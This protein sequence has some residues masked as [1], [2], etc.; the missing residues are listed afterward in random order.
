M[1]KGAA[2]QLARVAAP[3]IIRLRAGSGLSALT[4]YC[5]LLAGQ[6]AGSGWDESEFDVAAQLVN[7]PDATVLDVGAN[8]GSWSLELFRRLKGQPHFHMFECAPICLPEAEAAAKSMPHAV[9]VNAAV[10]DKAGT[11]TFYY[12]ARAGL[13]G[14]LGSLYQRQ[15]VSVEQVDYVS[16][17][18]RTIRLDDYASEQ[19]LGQIDLLK[20]DI[21][22]HELFALQ[23]ATGLLSEGRIAHLMFEFGSGNVN[24]RTFFR[25]FWD[26]LTG[27]GYRLGRIVPGGRV[28]PIERYDETL[29]YFR[30][31]TNHVAWKTSS[32]KSQ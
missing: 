17:D 27:Y 29:E 3:A 9:L 20:L 6:G 19:G 26:M 16:V 7:R 4:T 14:G 22:G 31:A 12:P 28:S 10:S 13:G 18:T 15:D 2:Q 23:G 11:A 1:L 25:D 21:E 8:N 32:T 24:S 30:G 5:H